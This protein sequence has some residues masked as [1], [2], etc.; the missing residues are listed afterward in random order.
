MAEPTRARNET[1]ASGMAFERPIREIES[2]LAE[3]EEISGR[4]NLDLSSEIAALKERLAEEIRK[5]YSHLTAWERVNVARHTQRPVLSDYVERVLDDFIELHG[6]KVFGDDK[7]IVTGFARIAERRFLLVGHRK[8]RTT[9]ERMAFNFGC[10]HPEGYRKAL[11]KMRLAAKVRLPIVSLI[12]TPGAYP[13]IGAEERGQAAA[14]AENILE[15]LELKT[16]ILV[17][18]IGE[19]GSGGAL[20]IGVGDRVLMMEHSYYSVI[21]PEGCAAILWKDGER[22]PEAAEALR[23]TASDLLQHGLIDGVIPEPAGGAHRAPAEAAATVR[24]TILAE[25]D[26][27]AREPLDR[28]LE[29]RRRKF[30]HAGEIAGR[31]PQVS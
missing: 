2:Q 25:L 19:G 17:I 22:T 31:F 6:D 18:V 13:G 5:T 8:G 16:P 20:G 15:M 26:L 9:K 21:S 27:L 3:L 7:A 30:R 29:R 11:R 1:T 14:I 10:A 4:T 24:K 12:N 23:L 28:L